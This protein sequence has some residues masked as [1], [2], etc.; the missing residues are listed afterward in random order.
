MK[1]R[2]SCTGITARPCHRGQSRGCG[3]RY[4][5]PGEKENKSVLHRREPRL[6]PRRVQVV[7]GTTVGNGRLEVRDSDEAAFN[8]YDRESGKSV[9]LAAAAML[10]G[11]SRDEKRD[12]ILTAPLDEVFTQTPV[13]FEAP[14]GSPAEKEEIK[15]ETKTPEKAWLPPGSCCYLLYCIEQSLNAV[16]LFPAHAEILTP[17]MAVGGEL[18]VDRTAQVEVTDDG[19]RAQVEHL[20]HRFGQ[21]GVGDVPVPKVSTRTD[22]GAATPIA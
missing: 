12:F 22:T 9:R 16:G 7:F 2:A 3:A 18:A 10:E 15:R 6:L 14:P 20:L 13:R 21:D 19:A 5:E 17:H 11:L 4:P 8:F 1:K